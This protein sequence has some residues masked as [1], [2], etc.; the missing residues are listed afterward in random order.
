MKHLIF[1]L[2]LLSYT[3]GIGAL[4]IF[5]FYYQKYRHKLTGR[6]IRLD[7]FF[8]LTLI[9]D[10]IN[11]Y[12]RM[13]SLDLSESMEFVLIF[14]LLAGSAGVVYY[15]C[16]LTFEA[17]GKGWGRPQQKI[18]AGVTLIPLGLI[19]FLNLLYHQGVIS[20]RLA[21]HSGF[22]MSNFYMVVCFFYAASVGIR[23]LKGLE[24]VMRPP[25][26]AVIGVSALL[27]SLSLL[28]N[29]IQ[30][31]YTLPFPLAFSPLVYFCVNLIFI[32]SAL[33]FFMGEAGPAT[34]AFEG[35]TRPI[36]LD[37]NLEGLVKRYTVSEREAEIIHWI[38]Q[39]HN[40]QEIGK[41]LF[42][43]PH[44]VKNHIYSI[45][46]KLGVKSRYELIN[47]VMCS[48]T[49]SVPDASNDESGD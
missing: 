36:A 9:F 40:N 13:L 42:I 31:K 7:L 19:V 21:V 2:Y 35:N 14:G 32:V 23:A 16:A 28:A 49:A 3:S 30:F 11:F 10:T 41:Q 4:T 5:A 39:G 38:V 44:T 27:L 1:L 26:K 22:S 29:V 34:T 25:V 45:Y 24:P 8:T 20:Q 48:Q 33:K 47:L 15:L 37:T 6:L 18:F 12:R 17:A 43:S 46:R